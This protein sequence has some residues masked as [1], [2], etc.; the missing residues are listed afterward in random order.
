[1]GHRKTARNEEFFG[2][3]VVNAVVV[4]LDDARFKLGD[5]GRVSRCHTILARRTRNNDHID[6]SLGIDGLV[7]H[8]KVEG[9][10]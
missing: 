7:G 8:R 1:M 10:R 9:D 4:N 3:W 6:F 2:L 5:D